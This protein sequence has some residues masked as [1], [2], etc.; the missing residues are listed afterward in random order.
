MLPF[1]AV[2][3]GGKI[4]LDDLIDKLAFRRSDVRPARKPQNPCVGDT[5]R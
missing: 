3:D 2:E 1:D 5:E 4:G